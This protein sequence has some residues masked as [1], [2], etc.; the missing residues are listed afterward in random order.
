MGIGIR[1]RKLW[2]LKA[3]VAI[4][5]AFA[6][7]AAVWS[8]YKIDLPHLSLEPRA[9]SMATGAAHVMVDTPVSTMIDIRQDTYSIDGLRNRAVLLGN[10]L[11]SSEI[12]A[13]IAKRAGVPLQRLRI[14]APLTRQQP[15]PPVD[16]QNARHTSDLLKSTDQYRI[17]IK[18]NATVPMMDIYAQTPNAD[19]AARLAN[20]A[21]DELKAYVPAIAA[22]QNTPPQDQIR[23]IQLGR[24]TGTVINPGVR[25][26]VALLAFVV[27]FLVCC[28]SLTFLSRVRAG[29]RLE[30]L[31]EATA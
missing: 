16:S 4:S 2:H 12:E 30:K 24:A 9:L 27:V 25:Y 31:S 5:L 7:F 8:V 11:A 14:L 22:A 3:G 18:V 29:W 13:R 20:A 17:A 26:Q 10:V 6:I 21:V 1:I 28:A 15:W 19:S 23:L